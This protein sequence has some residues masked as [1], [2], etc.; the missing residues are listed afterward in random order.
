MIKN[1]LQCNKE[2]TPKRADS[3]YCSP[4]CRKL[5]FR[6]KEISVPKRLSVP[7]LSVPKISV[8]YNPDIHERPLTENEKQGIT[9]YG[10][11]HNCKK[12]V[13]HLICICRDC[14]KQGITH[15]SIDISKCS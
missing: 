15:K 6:S 8:S 14:Y 5:A 11:C 12:Q 1:C 10:K 3:K 7:K 2:Y 4:N 9:E 13:S